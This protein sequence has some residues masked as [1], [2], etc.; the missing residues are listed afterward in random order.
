MG[1]VNIYVGV[2]NALLKHRP[3]PPLIKAVD[4][5]VNVYIGVLNALLKPHPL[6]PFHASN[7]SV[8]VSQ[9]VLSVNGEITRRREILSN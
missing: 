6:P 1:A 4:G 2:L 5:A 7:V 8:R 9:N 3:L